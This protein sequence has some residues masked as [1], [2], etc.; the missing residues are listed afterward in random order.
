MIPTKTDLTQKG[1]LG[2]QKVQMALDPTAT[3][4]I[5]SLLTD[6]YSDPELAVVREY[7][8]NAIDS[9][10][11]A[12]QA[13]P[14][15]VITPSTLSSFFKVKDYGIGLSKQDIID[16]YSKYGASLSRLTND[17]TGMLGL[18]CKSALTYTDQFNIK[19]I[20]DGQEIYV[21]VSRS[22]DG[23]GQ[24]EIV[25]ERETTE[26][27]SVEIIVPAKRYNSF[28]SKV[29]EFAYYAEPGSVLIDGQEPNVF[30]GIPIAENIF[31]EFGRGYNKVVMANVAYPVPNGEWGHS[32]A[33]R[34]VARVKPGEV[35]F[36]PSREQL[37]MTTLTKATLARIRKEFE[38]NIVSGI[39]DYISQL[40]T[41]ADVLKEY[42]NLSRLTIP[43]LSLENLTYRGITIECKWKTIGRFNPYGWGKSGKFN[44][45][46]HVDYWTLENA[47]IV[48]G[49]DKD[50]ISNYDKGKFRQWSD[51]NGNTKY[52]YVFGELPGS[53]W[54]DSLRSIDWEEIKAVKFEK[55]QK[56]EK[57]YT[58]QWM[59]SEE[60]VT[61]SDLKKFSK[62]TYMSPAEIKETGFDP[63]NYLP[64]DMPLVMINRNMW[65]KFLKDFPNA[66]HYEAGMK[67]ERDRLI[68]T[69]TKEQLLSARMDYY[70]T[71][72]CATLDENRI[73]DP[74]LKELVRAAKVS[75]DGATEKLL[76][77][78]RNISYH[79]R[80]GVPWINNDVTL[81]KYPLLGNGNNVEH[82][83]LYVNH[84]YNTLYKENNEV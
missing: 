3:A 72:L 71:S 54:T 14:V 41:H 10:K 8:T 17:A 80:M 16:V 28:E 67:A 58:I 68:S 35:N 34:I 42:Q 61:Q 47:L 36:T 1:D 6:L 11:V 63:R 57:T 32:Y 84:C 77:R 37:H 23:G 12:G 69:V 44:S 5:M 9:H 52:I 50:E 18:G 30:T 21:A 78:I 75:R 31:L 83:Y 74:E 53:P 33:Y 24:M 40:P 49:Y 59:N 4:H 76:V 51:V 13:R 64:Q 38:N 15:E 81:D 60:I 48:T 27:N 55:R 56:K 2:G 65:E 82:I 45:E 43:G 22:V 39:T 73:E 70:S 20:K 62:I 7:I 19:A 26:C 66:D 29:R 46:H 79:L 25:Y